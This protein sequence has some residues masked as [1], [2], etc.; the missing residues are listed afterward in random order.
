MPATHH[1]KA[2]GMVKVRAASQQRHRLFACVDEVIVFVAR[3]GCGPHAEDAVF[4]VQQHLPVG[5][6]VVGYQ[7]RHTNAQVDD[8]ALGDVL[9]HARGQLVFGAFLVAHASTFF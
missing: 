9:C 2:V 1:G 5:W 7:C 8:R 4:T 3:C 6:D